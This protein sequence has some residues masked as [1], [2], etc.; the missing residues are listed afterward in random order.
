MRMP[1]A[2]RSRP[3]LQLYKES[4]GNQYNPP[5][6]RSQS[7]EVLLRPACP[8]SEVEEDGAQPVLPFSVFA[9]C[10]LLDTTPSSKVPVLHRPGSSDSNAR[11]SGCEHRRW[12]ARLL[13]CG[14]SAGWCHS[15]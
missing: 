11:V 9:A 15:I 3:W 1:A 5:L 8:E 7:G 6:L 2:H 10:R 13:T 12:H 14:S 4:S